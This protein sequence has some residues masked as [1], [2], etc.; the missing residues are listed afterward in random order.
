MS[1]SQTPPLSGLRLN[2][3]AG[4]GF[5]Y[6]RTHRCTSDS[7]VFLGYALG[8]RVWG[9]RSNSELR[10]PKSERLHSG[11]RTPACSPTFQ[12]PNVC[13]SD[14]RTSAPNVCIPKSLQSNSDF[15]FRNDSVQ[16]SEC[17][18]SDFG[19]RRSDFRMQAFGFRISEFGF[20]IWGH[21]GNP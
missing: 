18:R 14:I 19:F 10:I 16:I 12:Y 7:Q 20:R 15:G 3:N 21:L 13:I 6:L 11:I 9:E 4:N 1:P 17:R 5:R 2:T 8:I